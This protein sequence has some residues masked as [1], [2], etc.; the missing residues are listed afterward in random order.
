MAEVPKGRARSPTLPP[1]APAIFYGSVDPRNPVVH[2]FESD[3][4]DC[5]GLLKRK[6]E[7]GAASSKDQE[8]HRRGTT[9]LFNIWNN[10]R[11]RLP[12]WYYNE[13]LVKIGDQ[14][15]E[16]KEHKLAFLYCYEQYLQQISGININKHGLDAHQLK[17][18]FFPNGFRDQSATR[19]LHVLQARNICLYKIVCD[20]DGD[21]LNQDS[22]KTCFNILTIL[23]LIM[24]ITLP[25]EHLCW[26]VYNGTVHMYT[27]CRHLMTIGQSA[28]VLEYLL[29]ASVCMESSI[30]LL[31]VH[32]LTWRATLY[33]AVCQCYYDCQSGIHG[34]VF[35]RR[36]LIKIDELK[37]MEFM[38]SSPLS[39]ETK[40]KFKEATVKMAAMIFKRTV[41]E[42]R[43]RP[44]GVLRPRIKANLKEAQHMPWP[45]TITERLLMEIFDCNSSIFLAIMEALFDKNRRILIPG[46][47]V[48][49]EIEVRDIISELCFA[50]ADILDGNRLY[51]IYDRMLRKKKEV[52]NYIQ[53]KINRGGGINVSINTSDVPSI[54]TTSSL[55]QQILAGKNGISADAAFRFIKIVFSY[56]EWDSF[57]HAIVLF[58]LFLQV[59]LPAREM[60]IDATM[61]LWQKCKVGIQKIQMSGR[62][63]L[64]FIHKYQTLKWLHILYVINEVIHTINLG[65]T[66]PVLIAEISLRLTSVME[67][68]ADFT[69]EDIPGTWFLQFS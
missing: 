4:S 35:A 7:A 61:F 58:Y 26:I 43:R 15:M 29:W 22:V 11:P 33:A 5:L 10:Y 17:S 68:I 13:T 51:I 40:K 28:K 36:G 53:Y 31:A 37:Q 41:F 66:N 46:P 39:T 48:P 57:D 56:E 23:Q 54:I 34:E 12:D 55:M 62:N 49:D 63:F 52:Q 19:T 21:L 50:G 60:I 14:L 2:R 20:K 25:H 27:I 32:Y 38:S 3:L 30:P 65:T 69:S 59:H 67:N 6:R 42:P 45:R 44:K 47:S 64:K 8:L 1:P 18:I 24:Q 9:S 16:M